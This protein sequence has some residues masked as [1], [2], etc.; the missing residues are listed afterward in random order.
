[1]VAEHIPRKSEARAQTR[2]VVVLVCRVVAG[3]AQAG[4]IQL[5]RAASV[6][7]GILPA[8]RELRIEIADMAKIVVERAQEFRAQAQ[9]Q[10]QIRPHF[11]VILRVEPEVVVSVLVIENAASAKAEIRR[12]N[13]Q[14]LK[15]RRSAWSVHEEQLSIEGLRK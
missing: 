1:M 14:F 6:D 12:P 4:H 9:V 11:P 7:K 15:I 10:R 3:A 5:V 8:I 13:N 2:R